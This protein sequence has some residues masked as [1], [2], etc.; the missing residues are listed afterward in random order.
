MCF[1][2]IFWKRGANLE[3]LGVTIKTDYIVGRTISVD[4]L[5][6]QEGFEAV[7]IGSGAGLPSFM[8]TE[9]G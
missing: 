8:G 2:R 5:F 9:N 4:E 7:F 6:E 1:A 3:K